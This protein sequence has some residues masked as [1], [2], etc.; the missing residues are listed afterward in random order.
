VQRSPGGDCVRILIFHGYLLRGTGSNIYNAE[1]A[2]TLVD[3]GH[4]VHLFC[5]ERNPAEYD[6]VDAVGRWKDG[7]LDIE[8]ARQPVRCTAYVPDIGGLLPVYVADRYEGLQARPF[9]ELTDAELERY[10]TANANAVRDAAAAVGPD[11]ALANHLVMGPVILARGL[12]GRVPYAVKIHGS[13]LEYTV[14]PN[15]ERFGGYAREGLAG[16]AGV[17]TGSRHTAE[18]LWE[19][20]GMPDLPARTRLLG[21]GVDVRR[22]H[23][24]PAAE[25]RDRLRRL[26]ARLE[27]D[28]PA[29]GGEADAA[30]AIRAADP[31]RDAIVSFV[32][33][34]I[35]AKGVDLLIAAWPLV[36]DQAP[37]ARLMIAGFGEYRQALLDLVRA[38]GEG[39]LASA[40]TIASR[41]REA[42]GGQT[43]ELH[44]LAAFL[45]GLTGTRRDRYLCAA[46][47]AMRR[48]HFAGRIEHDDVSEL[49]CASQAVVVPSTFPE[50]FGMVLA[51]A[52]CCGS[53]PLSADHSG[54]A[55]VTELLAPAIR[56]QLRPQLSFQLGPGAVQEIA[57]KL[58]AWLTF[59]ATRPNAW[60][61]ARADLTELACAEFGWQE[62]ARGVMAA[63]QGRLAGL[64]PI[65]VGLPVS[66]GHVRSPQPGVVQACLKEVM[67]VRRYL[68][69][70]DLLAID[71]HLHTDLISYLADRQ[72]QEPGEVV[73]LSLVTGQPHLP[74]T[75][76]LL[77]AQIGKF[78]VAPRPDHD[79][80][81]A[82]EHRMNQAVRD[83]AAIGCQASGVI[84]DEEDLAKAVRYET[85]TRQYDEVLLESD[86]QRGSGL[87][88]AL[89][90]DPVHKLRR[91]WGTRLTVFAPGLHPAQP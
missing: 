23:A 85:S 45:D 91:H 48:V 80:G 34:L 78:P 22:F 62:V 2:R 8:V 43:G 18:S 7:Q 55:E 13:A 67:D 42:E 74:P 32:G 81:A 39:D 76:L 71:E 37:A 77:G 24:R 52:A 70:L 12:A 72:E 19:V 28:P 79:I 5:Q 41:G 31:T 64:P 56:R 26:A 10:I 30:D 61:Q 25:A 40:R 3:L 57:D 83:L 66:A 11:V 16:A 84:S 1:L 73:V 63:A 58:S 89:H 68:L 21:P 86:G 65:P 4:D 46:R 54:L 53:M 33:K 47:S 27:T 14:R 44:Y 17:L 88:H 50:A 49:M 87:S 75:E 15:V 36:V 38:L 29:W 69:V 90:L 9:P 6:F 35:A 60:R 82:A 51:E 20:V 59:T